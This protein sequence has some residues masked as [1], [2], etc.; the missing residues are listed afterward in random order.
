V[1]ADNA[2]DDWQVNRPE[3]EQLRVFDYLIGNGDRH[4]KNL[5]MTRDETGTVHPVAIDHG[6]AFPLGVMFR[7]NLPERAFGDATGPLLP[8]T[9][10]FIASIDPKE[11]AG[12]LARNGVEPFAAAFTLRRL[13]RLKADP[14]FL[15][16]EQNGQVGKVGAEPEQGLSEKQLGQIDRIVD[17]AYRK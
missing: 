6:L 10:K 1:R 9:R 12:V 2:G 3:G 11:V 14:S 16:L 17:R 8:E 4:V 15:Q 7:W 13:E 5:M